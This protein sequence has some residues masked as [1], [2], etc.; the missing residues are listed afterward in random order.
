[1]SKSDKSFIDS[2]SNKD[3]ELKTVLRHFK[4]ST[5]E[6]NKEKLKG[7]IESYRSKKGANI[8]RDDFYKHFESIKHN[9]AKPK[10]HTKS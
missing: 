8:K 4:L 1:M 5:S 2:T 3:H 10:Q 6:K 9:Y 7:D